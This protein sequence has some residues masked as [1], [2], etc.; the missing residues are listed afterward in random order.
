MIFLGLKK[1]RPALLAVFIPVL[2]FGCIPLSAHEGEHKTF[3]NKISTTGKKNLG[4]KDEKKTN[5]KIETKDKKEALPSEEK[6]EEQTNNKT[7]EASDVNRA[8]V[9]PLVN[10][11]STTASSNR[12]SA[13]IG[14]VI[15]TANSSENGYSF[16]GSE[17]NSNSSSDSVEV[18]GEDPDSATE[19]AKKNM[20]DLVNRA[21][22][23]IET[24]VATNPEE[25]KNGSFNVDDQITSL[26]SIAHHTNSEAMCLTSGGNG[27]AD[28]AQCKEWLDKDVSEH[29]KISGDSSPLERKIYQM[30][31]GAK[32]K[33]SEGAYRIWN[34]ALRTGENLLDSHGRLNI[35]GLSKYELN[36]EATKVASELGEK[37]AEQALKIVLGDE[38]PKQDEII[39]PPPEVLRAVAINITRGIA[40]HSVAKWTGIQSAKKGI[41]VIT[42]T[43]R[44]PQKYKS[45]VEQ[46]D[47]N[48]SAEERLQAQA[49]L[50][51][52]T[53]GI[54]LEDRVARAQAVKKA[55]IDV[56]N[57]SFQG[58]EWVA[59]DS[60][61]ERYD[62]WAYRAT[63]EQISNPFIT[64][65]QIQKPEQI[66]LSQ[67]QIASDLS[68]GPEDSEEE[69]DRKVQIKQLTPKDQIEAYNRQLEVAARSM[70]VI[71]AES[72][73]FVNT[74]DKIRSHKLG[75]GETLL[76]IN[77]LT[78][79]QKKNNLTTGMT[80]LA[81]NPNSK[82]VIPKSASQL[83]ITNF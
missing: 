52:E 39:A 76:T 54:S 45:E 42:N 61:K 2:L 64:V 41:E 22:T 29:G 63:V 43:D 40:N 9:S 20:T 53:E 1:E 50:D 15:S 3:V 66:Q 68:V 6:L 79:A 83:T 81:Q 30:W 55:S 10:S 33:I 27:K 5:N 16:L 23:N 24:S 67:R 80:S 60:N 49:P 13:V 32:Q 4:T 57:P 26:S 69:G 72:S 56:V 11:V 65:D 36:E 34:I 78:P 37:S 25:S 17:Q 31:E 71:S 70:E 77:D 59:G 74:A 82:V 51:T 46:E 12:T 7:G 62:E 44:D 48:A 73:T 38:A 14:V 58:D 8:S 47:N 75:E 18:N 19:R 21:N 35:Q 28:G